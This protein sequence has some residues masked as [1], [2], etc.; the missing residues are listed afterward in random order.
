MYTDFMSLRMHICSLLVAAMF[1]SCSPAQNEQ[2]NKNASTEYTIPIDQEISLEDCLSQSE[3]RY[4]IYFYSETC[5]HCQQIKSDIVSFANDQIMKTYFID[6]KK[7]NNE[8]TICQKDEIE[9][10]ISN[11]RDLK[12]LGTPTIVMVENGIVTKN[13][14]GKEECLTIINQERLN[15]DKQIVA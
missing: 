5:G 2:S 9:L 12:I 13:V 7:P 4:L 15:N 6:I 14:S 10:G 11:Y 8:V 3:S 1:V